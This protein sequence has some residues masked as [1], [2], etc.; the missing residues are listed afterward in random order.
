MAILFLFLICTTQGIAQDN[1]PVLKQAKPW[2]GIAIEENP[3]GV[4][5]KQAIDDTPA[6]QAGLTKGDIIT[7]IDET[8]IATPEKLI[9]FV[10]MKGVGAE[11]VVKYLRDNKPQQKKITLVG[12]PDELNLL[13]QKVL[14]KPAPNFELAVIGP[15]KTSGKLADYRGKVVILE[16]WATW[17]P[18]CNATHKYLNKLLEM[19]GDKVAVLTI[20]NEETEELQKF[21]DTKK[22]KFAVL[23]D[24]DGITRDHWA[25]SAIPTMAVIDQKGVVRN[26]VIGGGVY[27]Q[28]TIDKALELIK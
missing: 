28:E 22:P 20:S 6:A 27:L 10:Q 14:D 18:A 17:C 15:P 26:V 25:F 23:Q 2:L 21:Y 19:H 5:I 24:K 16:F 11:V 12:R 7:H 13:K 3:K 9:Q 4:F 8:A 1:I